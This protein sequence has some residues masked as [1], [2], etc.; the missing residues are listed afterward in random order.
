MM[1]DEGGAYWISHTAL[2]QLFDHDD[3]MNVCKHNLDYIRQ[4]TKEYFQVESNFDMLRHL[5]TDFQKSVMAGFTVKLAQGASQGDNL[6]L[7]VFADA[8]V[9]LAKHVIAVCTRSNLHKEEI[10]VICVGSVWKSWGSMA[11]SFEA[12][13]APLF[14]QFERI[15]LVRLV[16]DGA[17]GAA[18]VGARDTGYTVPIDYSKHTQTMCIISKP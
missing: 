14:T 16:G 12:T 8:G 1:G 9:Q 10:I 4:S 7:S 2:K 3:N 11:A 15:R 17:I 18:I 13:V 6:C 5:Y